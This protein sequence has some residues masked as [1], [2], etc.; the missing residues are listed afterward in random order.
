MLRESGTVVP[1]THECCLCPS[2]SLPS[3]RRQCSTQSLSQDS[4]GGGVLP[5]EVAHPPTLARRQ[6]VH[7]RLRSEIIAARLR[8]GANCRPSTPDQRR[9][10]AHLET[11]S[12]GRSPLLLLPFRTPP[13]PPLHPHHL[14]PA[15]TNSSHTASCSLAISLTTVVDRCIPT[16]AAYR[17]GASCAVR[18]VGCFPPP[19]AAD[20]RVLNSAPPMRF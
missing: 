12:P 1:A 19:V 2:A 8:V 9:L 16:T 14:T 13:P 3:R 15:G 5:P 11:T 10:A 7:R 20:P 17:G 6:T 18:K 4:A